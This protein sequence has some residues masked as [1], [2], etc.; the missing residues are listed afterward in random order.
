MKLRVLPFLLLLALLDSESIPAQS[1][2]PATL[3]FHFE[4]PGLPVPDYTVTLHPD[5]NG[6]YIAQYAPPSRQSSRYGGVDTSASALAAPESVSMPLQLSAATTARLFESA[7]TVG[8]FQHPCESKA[9]NI[10]NTGKKV[11]SYTGPDATGTCIYNY[12]ENKLI[13]ALTDT[14]LG[15]AF[16]LDEGHTLANRHRFD[17]LGLDSEMMQ[18]TEAVKEGRALEVGVI[19]PVLRSIADDP[20]LLDR[21]RARAS[22]LLAADSTRSSPQ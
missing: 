15:I 10:A 19:A 3:T 16:T 11:L 18:L 5:G 6:T 17:H 1:L 8:Y 22:Q 20:Q 7:R 4:R 13:S 14:F 12:T 9:K 21:V 2:T